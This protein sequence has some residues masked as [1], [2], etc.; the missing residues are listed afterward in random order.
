[1]TDARNSVRDD[2]IVSDAAIRK[3]LAHEMDRAIVRREFTRKEL[4]EASGVNIH[5]IDAIRT[6][7]MGKQRRVTLED[8]FSI[9]HALGDRAVNA[10]LG[11]IGYVARKLDDPDTIQPMQIAADGMQHLATIA[12]AAADGRIDHTERPM[13]T[14]AADM[15]IATVLPLSSHG[16]VGE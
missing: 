5:T 15:L 13:T 4:A 11:R 12:R 10:L 2:P 16:R 3:V 7:D 8:A 9:S 14:E 1:M 6:G